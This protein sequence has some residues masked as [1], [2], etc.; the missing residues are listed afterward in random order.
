LS[1]RTHHATIICYAARMNELAVDRE[2]IAYHGNRLEY[3]TIAWNSLE[4]LI[5]IGAGV[6]AGSITL[7]DFGIDSLIEVTS[8]ATLL[9]RVSADANVERRGQTKD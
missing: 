1:R 7:V 5:G 8:G 3:S 2:A 6:I 4:G 9:W